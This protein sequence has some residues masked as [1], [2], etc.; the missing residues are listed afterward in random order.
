MET[1][2]LCDNGE[3]YVT[4]YRSVQL[5]RQRDVKMGKFLSDIIFFRTLIKLIKL[6][7]PYKSFF[8]YTHDVDNLLNGLFY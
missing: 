2:I 6:S 1:Y 3:Y 4:Q 5:K 7:I 8:I